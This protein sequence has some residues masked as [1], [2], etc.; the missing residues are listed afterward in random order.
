M[1][2][3]RVEIKDF[4]VFK[5]E[6]VVDFCPGINVIIG[7]NGTGKTTLL[8]A[9]YGVVNDKLP[10]CF[11]TGRGRDAVTYG[12]G[13]VELYYDTQKRGYFLQGG[14][15]EN[16]GSIIHPQDS[17]VREVS[18]STY[19]TSGMY[20]TQSVYIPEKDMLSHSYGLLALKHER[21]SVPFDDTLTDIIA[22]A[23]LY[24]KKD[25]KNNPLFSR[26]REIIGGEVVFENDEFFISKD[27]DNSRVAFSTEAS[28][29]KKLGLLWKLMQ[30][31]MLEKDS[32]LFWDEP[33][34]SLNPEYVPVLVDVLLELSR[35]G[36]QVFI[37]THS[38]LLA[39]YFDV[40]KRKQDTVM[41]YSLYK[42]G[43]GVNADS[44]DSFEWLN[45]NNLNDEPVRLYE[46]RLDKVFGN[47]NN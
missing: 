28:G 25:V 42:D 37:A 16:A 26:I 13:C 22:K 17:T 43:N 33:E 32:I 29:Y 15:N 20:G 44:N 27:T 10:S 35:N 7:A 23:Q 19:I 40:L 24:P 6:F 12:K 45:P 8:K 11:Y 3:A 41:F 47:E 36:V 18:I 21:P 5:G 30:N 1:V 14:C 39:N 4:L 2:I 34:N 9:M 46:L 38:E 31:G